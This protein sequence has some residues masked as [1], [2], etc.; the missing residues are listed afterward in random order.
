MEQIRKQV[1]YKELLA[2]LAEEATELAQAALKVRRTL[3]DVN[4]TPIDRVSAEIEMLEEMADVSLCIHVLG[5][6][7]GQWKMLEQEKLARW[8][9]R[10]TND[11]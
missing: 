1:P 3:D 5:Y 6:H 11:Q 7:E 9:E 2:Q 4:P 8:K 10:L